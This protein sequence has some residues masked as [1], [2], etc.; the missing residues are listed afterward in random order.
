MQKWG[1]RIFSNPQLG[2]RVYIRMIMRMVYPEVLIV[3]TSIPLLPN[4][5]ASPLY[6]NLNIVTY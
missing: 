5:F 6:N 3:A 1:E 4:S 2:M